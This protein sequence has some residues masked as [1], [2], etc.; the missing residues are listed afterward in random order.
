MN[1]QLNKASL[2]A[3]ERLREEAAREPDPVATGP[4][5]RETQIIAIYGKAASASRS[6][7][8]ISAT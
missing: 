3:A 2:N 5:K 6:P 7:W 4:V 8:P 1:V